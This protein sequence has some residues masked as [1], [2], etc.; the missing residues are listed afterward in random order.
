VIEPLM[1][2]Q[3]AAEALKVSRS[4][5]WRLRRDGALQAILVSRCRRITQ[6]EVARYIDR[7]KRLIEHARENN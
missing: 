4:T 7:K 2:L 5:L 6:A 1:T 3:E